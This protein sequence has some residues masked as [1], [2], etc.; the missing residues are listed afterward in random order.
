MDN[1]MP[2]TRSCSSPPSRSYWMVTCSTTDIST[3]L[4]EK[5]KWERLVARCMFNSLSLSRNLIRSRWRSRSNFALFAQLLHKGGT[6]RNV[7]QVN[8]RQH[9]R[10]N[11]RGLLSKLTTSLSRLSLR[12]TSRFIWR[13]GCWWGWWEWDR[14]PTTVATA[15]ATNSTA[16]PAHTTSVSSHSISTWTVTSHRF[17]AEN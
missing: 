6:G 11:Y 16:N 17:H 9:R 7:L 3:L 4:R 13:G 8:I 15:T 1:T 10:K 12:G 2:S 5:E 14:I